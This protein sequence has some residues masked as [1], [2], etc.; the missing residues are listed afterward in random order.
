[1]PYTNKEELLKL[2]EIDTEFAAVRSWKPQL[3]TCSQLRSLQVLKKLDLPPPDY[4]DIHAFK[5]I[6]DGRIAA[7]V[8]ALGPPPLDIKQTDH[9]VPI[10]DGSTV[11]V[12]YLI[13]RGLLCRSASRTRKARQLAQLR[14]VARR[15]ICQAR[16]FEESPFC[17]F[18][19][20]MRHLVRRS[21]GR[22]RDELTSCNY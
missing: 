19:E 10:Y 13:P 15:G 18:T 6:A 5:K 14:K 7:S 16:A 17:A 2:G 20:T 22:L 11:R 9:Q 4:S 1:M 21:P 12:Q 8:E 3:T